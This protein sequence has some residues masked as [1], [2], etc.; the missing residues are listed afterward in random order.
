[1]S[2]IIAKHYEK[3]DVAKNIKSTKQKFLWIVHIDG[4]DYTIV[5]FASWLSHK[6]RITVNGVT[7][8]EKTVPEGQKTF[9]WD[10]VIRHFDFKIK[11]KEKNFDLYIDGLLFDYVQKHPQELLRKGIK[12]DSNNM[13]VKS[14]L[15]MGASGKR[16]SFI[17]EKPDTVVG[18][19]RK[20]GPSQ[21]ADRARVDRVMAEEIDKE[22]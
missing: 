7:I 18:P 4:K 19:T 1:M 16:V 2:S 15:K 6:R 9:E 21:K 20:A 8:T 12:L 3:T 14:S 22:Q 10:H 11:Q 13:P 17:G 5:L